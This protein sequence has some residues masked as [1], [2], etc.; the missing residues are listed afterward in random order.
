MKL[1]LAL[2]EAGLRATVPPL[3]A[4]SDAALGHGLLLAARRPRIPELLPH[5]GEWAH[6]Q[7]TPLGLE[8]S[9]MTTLILTVSFLAAQYFVMCTLLSACRLLEQI[10]SGWT[11]ERSAARR[12]L[13]SAEL[14][15]NIA[16]M[17]CALFL[18]AQMQAMLLSEG[19]SDSPGW[20]L[21]C[22]EVAAIT[23]ALQ[24][25]LVVLVPAITGDVPQVCEDSVVLSTGPTW[26]RVASYALMV[27][28]CGVCAG[29]LVGILTMDQWLD[30]PPA[31]A[32]VAAS[33][34]AVACTINLAVQFFML[35][36]CLATVAGTFGRPHKAGVAKAIRVLRL[37]AHT[38]FYA[39]MLCV[40]FV[41]ARIRAL[42]VDPLGGEPQGWAEAAFYACS[43]TVLL[44]SLVAMIVPHLPG[45]DARCSTSPIKG[46]LE[47]TFD[48]YDHGVGRLVF[49]LAR[50]VPCAVMCAGIVAIVASMMVISSPRGKT[51]PFPIALQ[52][53]S[54]LA[55]MFFS[56][57]LASWALAALRGSL[58][59]RHRREGAWVKRAS[60]ALQSAYAAV[61]F[62]PMLGVLFLSLRL[63]A[64]Q[65]T[66][67]RG[68]PQGWAHDAMY[69]CTATVFL[70]L[71]LCLVVALKPKQEGGRQSLMEFATAAEV[72]LSLTLHSGAV[73]L[74]VAL[75]CLTP[76]TAGSRG[77]LSLP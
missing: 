59:R 63:R 41:G 36:M 6:A 26:A 20:V 40:L 29:I 33:S 69:V 42:H 58:A 64:Q 74:C 39:P 2:S 68:W 14:T 17:L 61:R 30:V 7:K 12:V 34:P 48:G 60:Q 15:V 49:G 51:P 31:H 19:R 45:G 32:G 55:V 52:C 16:P 50:F 72:G 54:L 11:A 25:L 46:D 5:D 44:Q 73:A 71:V 8:L 3:E 21:R 13:E 24:T 18:A 70:Q 10:S 35:Q 9:P 53:V 4:L 75:F 28:L 65:V 77:I 27:L 76:S 38:V 22:M 37:A 23:V 47:I 43:Y 1:S 66:R 67:H 62:C 56:V 57:S